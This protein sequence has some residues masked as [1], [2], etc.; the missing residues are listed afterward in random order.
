[1]KSRNT[2]KP[3]HAAKAAASTPNAQAH[4]RFAW[5]GDTSY[6]NVLLINYK[7][8]EREER[9]VLVSSSSSNRPLVAIP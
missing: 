2:S 6:S 3:A 4:A 8:W 5:D 7:E 1:M 9:V